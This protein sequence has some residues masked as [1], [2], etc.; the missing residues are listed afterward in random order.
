MAPEPAKT[1]LA[2][3]TSVVFDDEPETARFVFGVSISAIVKGSAL[4]ELFWF[5]VWSAMS[6]IVGASFTG[7]TVNAKLAVAVSAPSLTVIVMVVVPL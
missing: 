6:L 1:M 7:V 5:I 3:G 2:L 4:V